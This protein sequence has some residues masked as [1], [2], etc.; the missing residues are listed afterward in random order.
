MT[1]S[2]AGA[3]ARRELALPRHLTHVYSE[4]AAIWNPIHTE[5]A[6]ARAAGLAGTIVHGTILWA[7]AGVALAELR[8]GGEFGRMARLNGR[9][10]GSL[11]PGDRAQ[12]A[13]QGDGRL[14]AW[15]VEDAADG[16]IC[17]SG[18]AELR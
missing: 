6:V 8:L 13:V 10:T 9:F 14:A 2:G 12:V 11:A 3:L 17:V 5:V 1:P 7:L 18:E 15:R 4:C 16:R